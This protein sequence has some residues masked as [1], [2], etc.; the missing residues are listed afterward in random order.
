MVLYSPQTHRSYNNPPLR[1]SQTTSGMERPA[2]T[3]PLYRATQ[4][5][6]YLFY[7]IETILVFRFAFKL[8]GANTAAGFTRF[9]YNLS[10]P[11]LAPFQLVLPAP[12]VSG[13]IFEWSTL[14]AMLVYWII[15]WGIVRLLLMGKPV[16][17]IEANQKLN[18]QDIEPENGH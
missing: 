8:I 6:W 2:K 7:V 17:E 13:S 9:I 15:A 4:A 11:L 3:R 16:S 12:R 10:D 5:I 1:T 14:L 18:R